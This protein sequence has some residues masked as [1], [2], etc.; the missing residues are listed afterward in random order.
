MD[1]RDN[2]HGAAARGTETLPQATSRVRFKRLVPLVVFMMASPIA[3]A[4]D[5]VSPYPDHWGD[6]PQVQTRDYVPLPAG[7]GRG[8]STLA[9]WI[10]EN[11][12]RDQR[13][14]VLPRQPDGDGSVLLSG[15]AM[16]WHNVTLTLS[17]PFAHERDQDPNPFL[18]FRFTVTWTHESGNVRHEVPGYFAADGGAAETSGE[19]GTQWR[20]HFAPNRPGRWRY[21]VAFLQG[22]G[23]AV[24]ESSGEPL[25]DW[26][27]RRG[28]IEVQPTD[29]VGRDLRAH[30][31]LEYVGTRYLRFA[32]SGAYFLKAGP[33]APETLL[34]YGDFDGTKPGRNATRRAGEA[35]P[36]KGLHAYQPHVQDWRPGDPSW[37][38]GRGKG[39]IGAINY[40]AEKGVNSISFLPYN[41][42]GDG[43]NVW[44]FAMRH[45]KRHYD[46]SKLDQWAI[47]FQH[48]SQQGMH[49]HFKLQENEMDDNR[50][51]HDGKLAD[52][53]ESLDGGLL[54]VERKLYCRELIARYGHHLAI[55]WNV[56]E[57]N[58]QSTSEQQ[59][60]IRYLSETDPYP[61]HIVVHTFPDQQDQVYRPLLGTQSLLTGVSLQNSWSS[62][63]RLTW[64]WISQSA[65]AGRPWVVTNDEQNPASHGV[66]PDPGYQGHDGIAWQGGKP[67][68]LNDIRKLCLWG[69]LL[70]GGGG[71]EYYF[72]YDLPQNDLVCEDF[73]SRDR[74]WDY[75]R[76][77]LEFFRT[78]GVPFWEM[79]NAD[80][81]VENP[82]HDN[83]RYCFAKQDLLLVYLPDG[84][85]SE[86]DLTAREGEY[87]VRWF[88]PRTGGSLQ[89][90]SIETV[91]AG[92]KVELGTAPADV[93][94]D[95]LIVV[96]KEV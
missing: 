58:T 7:Y 86:L 33:D 3:A 52:V 28:E 76:I 44:P 32:G 72:G 68:D 48:A 42:G 16:Q 64:K 47:V 38:Q 37:R 83:S 91:T 30:G 39:L 9:K 34:A 62:A 29:K 14:L 51:G 6:P 70:A 69:T 80:A 93:E 82:D 31:C 15:T 65:R 5:S 45:D 43:D 54:G 90:G 40:L 22:P 10:Q 27:D 73:R 88:N 50:A 75:C 81:L 46:C 94:Q 25:A 18:D 35:A 12:D 95:W 49:L 57:E 59:A 2:T 36:S 92:R 56:G 63:H 11:L 20:A 79:E 60:M 61:H 19:A 84:G 89:S 71:V 23:A 8:S 4:A 78:Q 85:T 26:H 55:T 21:R 53:P 13:P 74:S 96:R 87:T 24:D 1:D 77:A 66:P 41:A 17:G 67:Y